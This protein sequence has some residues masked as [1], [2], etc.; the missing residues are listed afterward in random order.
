M[1]GALVP[2]VIDALVVALALAVPARHV[3]GYVRDAAG[4]PLHYRLNGL[5]VFALVVAAYA[6]VCSAGWLPW[7]AL[8]RY[9]YASLAS[10]VVLGLVFTAAIVIGA[11]PTGRSRA[12][13][14]YFGRRF[15]PQL[16][17][18]R[19]DAKMVLYL[20]GAVLLGLHVISFTAHQ[21]LAFPDEPVWGVYVYA[22]AFLWFVSEYLFFEEVHLYTYDF[23]AERVGFKLGWG[24]IAFYP[25]FY[26]VGLWSAAAHPCSTPAWLAIAAA[27]IFAAGWAISRGANLQKFR[28]KT[29]PTATFLGIAPVALRDGEHALLCSGFW[30]AAR[31]INYLSLIH[32]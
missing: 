28:F 10:A 24:C 5:R 2:W 9:R 11:P 32:I 26:C 23:I 3:T 4:Q 8:W 20:I 13:D 17:D 25:Y 27:I 14:V 1:I 6:G 12:A 30:G 16:G 22:G 15:N 18:G 7:D 29:R 21:R 31:H 19:L